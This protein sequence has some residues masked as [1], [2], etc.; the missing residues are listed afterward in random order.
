MGQVVRFAAPG[1]VVLVEEP[2]RAPAAD[3]VRL[4]TRYSGISAGTELTAYRGSNPYLSRRW[5]PE[6]R[7]FVIGDASYAYPLDGWGYEEVGRV[8]EVGRAVDP[9]LLGRMVWGTW[10]HR[11]THVVTGAYAETRLLSADFDPLWAIF[12]R[13]GAIA[14]NGLHDAEVNL[15]ETIAVFGLGVPGLLMTQLC[16]LSGV[17]VLAVD[18]IEDRLTL[19]RRFGATE[20]IDF[21]QGD[22]AERIRALTGGRGADTSIEVSGS[23][24]ALQQA[25]RSTAYNSRVVCVGFLQGEGAAL[26]L[27]EEFH[28]NRIQLISSQTSGVSARS[29]HRWDRERLERTVMHLIADKRLDVG[30]LVTHVLPVA[31]AGAAFALLDRGGEGALQVVLDFGDDG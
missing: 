14:L 20:A 27:G 5:D 8:V 9:A 12:A 16:L 10:G 28:H 1:H 21:R 30:A 17:Q 31:E 15:G 19:A 29:A 6:R 23:H 18:G 26:R 13:I 25:I 7:L 24:A 3:E 22:P 2:E 4:R 11:A